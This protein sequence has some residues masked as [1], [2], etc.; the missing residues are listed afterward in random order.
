[1]YFTVK[2]GRKFVVT[3]SLKILPHLIC[4]A[5]LPCEMS[6]IALKPATTITNCVIN[7]D[8]ACHVA[9]PKQCELKSG[10]PCCLG[11]PSTDG[12]STSTVHDS[13]P[14]DWHHCHIEN[15]HWVGQTVAAFGWSHHW[16]VAS[17]VWV[18]RLAARRT[19]WTF[20]VKTARCDSCL[21][22]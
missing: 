18:R 1:M 15:C 3:L 7:V 21:R 8:Q 22:Q 12:L 14:A 2:I 5:T 16:S 17:P 10:R 13:Q 4:V 11:G 20:D 19:H 9:L 6:D